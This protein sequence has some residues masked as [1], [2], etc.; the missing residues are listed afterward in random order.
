MTKSIFLS[1]CLVLVATSL[2]VYARD[3][4]K[5]DEPM[6]VSVAQ[7]G[8]TPAQAKELAPQFYDVSVAVSG[9][10]ASLFGLL[11]YPE[12]STTAVVARTGPVMALEVSPNP[13]I[14]NV[15]FKTDLGNKSLDEYLADPRSRV[16]GFIVVHRGRIV[17]EQYPGMRPNDYHLWMSVTKTAASHMV[18]LLEEEGLIDVNCSVTDYLPW[19]E[20][21]DW[22]AVK[23]TDA[24]DMKAGLNILED[25]ATR[26]DPGSIANRMLLAN[27]GL[28]YNG[29]VETLQ[30]VISSA[31][32]VIPPGQAYEY[33]SI[34][35][36]ILVYLA[37]AVTGRRWNDLFHER[38]WS[39]MGV[40]G[41][42]VMG[43]NPAGLAMA[44]GEANTRL[45]DLARYGMLY[46]PSWNKVARDRLV[47][48]SYVRKLSQGG[49]PVAFRNGEAHIKYGKMFADET[50]TSNHYQ[51]DVI[52][53][54]GDFH[55]NG[56]Q[57]QGLY[58]SP[59]KDL[60][61]A[62]FSTKADYQVPGYARAIAK[63]LSGK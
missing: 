56:Q 44:H 5:L 29:K 53:A 39:K 15:R 51:W 55:K 48:E 62:Y 61:I 24:L 38:V 63:A 20:G 30:E 27:G 23:V 26:V 45:Q 50:A 34:N 9:G 7:K 36:L 32:R 21:T 2:S 58:V 17:Y 43:V 14:G 40:E 19:L 10:D 1:G 57:G 16:Q 11:N 13:A 54:D 46:T 35:T 18:W 42:M 60:V 6:P 25:R 12:I 8:F 4:I 49:D 37:E 52:F 22:E 31:K 3:K 41:D 33:S 28:P 59:S 47:S